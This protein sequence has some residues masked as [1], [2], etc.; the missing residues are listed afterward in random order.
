MKH[1]NYGRLIVIILLNLVLQSSVCFSQTNVIEEAKMYYDRFKLDSCRLLL[2]QLVSGN[3]HSPSAKAIALQ[4][5]A[6]QDWRLYR[7]V[8]EAKGKLKS[9]ISLN[10][11]LHSAFLLMAQIELD[12]NDFEKAKIAQANSMQYAKSNSEIINSKLLFAQIIYSQNS[13]AFRS[14]LELDTIAIDKASVYLKEILT[15]QPGHQ[16]AS[17]LLMGISIL[18]SNGR[19]LFRAWKSYFFIADTSKV[20][21]VLKPS[22]NSFSLL[23]DTWNKND[24]SFTQLKILCKA[25]AASGFYDYADLVIVGT[26]SAY[27]EIIQNDSEIQDII[28][29]AEFIKGIGDV[30]K[31]FYPQIATG[32][33]NY[34]ENYDR[35]INAV[36]IELWKYMDESGN[37]QNFNIDTF[38]TRIKIRFRADG[39]I[40][41][42]VGYYSLLLGL[43]VEDD[44]KIIEQYGYEANFGVEVLDRLISQ[45]FT[46]WYG[47]TNVGGWGTESS[48]IQIRG[49]YLRDPF[50]RLLWVTDSTENK[51][52]LS[53]IN[54]L[55]SDDYEKCKSDPYAE[56]SF[57]A[58]Q[59]RYDASQE[60]YSNL[61]STYKSEE[62]LNLAFVSECIRLNIESAVFGHEGRHAIDQLFFKTE[63]DT[64][65]HIERELRAKYSEVYFSSNPKLALTGSIF[66][67]NL[68][69]T[70]Y[71]GAANLIFRKQIYDWMNQ[72]KQEING[73]TESVP[74]LMQMDL[75]SE[76]QIRLICSSND[77]L[78][79]IRKD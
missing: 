2:Q 46:T 29:F 45:D 22:C 42:T 48:V 15:L 44:S 67:S 74:V 26:M 31:V 73:F 50:N 65:S 11:D 17:D 47:A 7:N 55:K 40:G 20:N 19:D 72:H 49:A 43:I 24:L 59:L 25:L 35:E 4:T 37:N 75:L 52:I 33:R 78:Y 70:T 58:L 62:E 27:Y 32:L 9:A 39:Y 77:P 79:R 1:K 10:I 68:D 34:E 38:I 76:E 36:C 56:P 54:S 71:H 61:K 57:M 30:N 8:N 5:L 14:K 18:N 63:F 12:E 51:M 64:L 41:T 53:R 69:T 21:S 3:E 28:H 13:N 60:I 16:K 66:G 6:E 23:E